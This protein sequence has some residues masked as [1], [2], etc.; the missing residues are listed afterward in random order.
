MKVLAIRGANLASLEGEFELD[1]AEGPLARAGVFAICGA[2][3]SGKSTLLDAMCLALFDSAPRLEGRV[4]VGRADEDESEWLTTSDPRSILRKGAGAGFAE[5]DFL[6][7]DGGRYRARWQAH[8][9][10][11]KA[12]GKLQ[13]ST[14]S[15][16]DLADGQALG[17]GRKTDVLTAI[18][19]HLG[20]TYVQFRRSVLLAQN[21]FAAF[22]D[23]DARERAGLLERMTGTEIYGLISMEAHVRAGEERRLLET[24]SERSTRIEVL[25]EAERGEHERRLT[26][27][28]QQVLANEARAR[29]AE[30]AVDWHAQLESLRGEERA[31]C[32]EHEQTV[33]QLA[34]AESRR[35]ELEAYEAVRSLRPLLEAVDR[36][37]VAVSQRA[38]ELAR[39]ETERDARIEQLAADERAAGAAQ[40]ALATAERARTDAAPLL[41]RA[42]RL[43]GELAVERQ[44]VRE[45]EARLDALR[46]EDA[47]LAARE[48][49]L[50]AELTA[51]GRQTED[52]SAWLRERERWAG[53]AEGWARHEPQLERVVERVEAART[54]R[55]QA[56]EAAEALGRAQAKHERAADAARLAAER[57]TAAEAAHATALAVVDDAPPAE[58][59][60]D[61][62][63]RW[64]ERRSALDTMLGMATSAQSAFEA[65][66][67]QREAADDAARRAADARHEAARAERARDEIELGLEE[68]QR[69]RDALRATLDLANRRAE[70]R[71]GEPCPLCGA[72]EHPFAH[73]LPLVES[74][75]NEQDARVGALGAERSRLERRAAEAL[76]AAK[77]S[78]DA[79]QRAGEEASR[80]AEQLAGER[81]RYREAA[82]RLGAD[83]ASWPRDLPS[84]QLPRVDGGP[85]LA[86]AGGEADGP[87]LD[88]GART[89]LEAALGD[90]IEALR[91]VDEQERARR[92]AERT[93]DA[94]RTTRDEARAEAD[95]AARAEETAR[96]TSEQAQRER[97]RLEQAA[98]EAHA[99]VRGAVEPLAHVLADELRARLVDDPERVL[100]EV[101][102]EVE[103]W[104]ARSTE[105][106]RAEERIRALQPTR[107]ALRE[108]RAGLADQRANAHGELEAA[109][110]ALS[111]ARAA[112]QALLGGEDAD[113]CEQRLDGALSQARAAAATA[114][115]AVATTRVEAADR[116]ARRQSAAQALAEA[117]T[118]AAEVQARLSV[119]CA[120]AGVTEP[121]ARARLTRDPVELD[122]W[123]RELATLDETR[124][125]QAAV[126]TERTRKREAHE[127]EDV[128]TLAAEQARQAVTEARERA[129]SS[130]ELLAS[131]RERLMRDDTQRAELRALE[132]E[133]AARREQLEVWETLAALIGSATGHKLRVFAQSLTLELLL[134]HANHHLRT[135]APRYALARVPGEDLA[136]MVIDR[137]MGD[138]VRGVGSLSG[139]ESFLVALGMAL[140]LASLSSH[141]AQI[142]S[143]FIDEGFGAL[144]P[145]SLDVVLHALDALQANGRQIGV[146]SHVQAMAERFDTRVQVVPRGPA[147]SRVE[148]VEGF[149]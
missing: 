77:G 55:A 60:A 81:A 52:A 72:R 136:L 106:A 32:E 13:P 92:E 25:P 4:R 84:V 7:I 125:R 90:A 135:L 6:G 48:G 87:L 3:G 95:R 127:R 46:G 66:R 45:R 102:R 17:G 118:A 67:R 43:E 50:E 145:A 132:E 9:A 113:A 71:E 100:D 93:A 112:R 121:D 110:G 26:E 76:E 61:V 128:P 115:R 73:E 34:L 119:A 74:L 2:T 16:L 131:I 147:R 22:L 58:R 146:I 117:H 37:E 28:D 12:R 29:D 124:R 40:A 88:A 30:R 1:L 15:L 98:A 91:R 64:M 139:G 54:L 36:A 68:A 47:R 103:A 41:A 142:G 105:R 44:H 144:D 57:A 51:C 38:T 59:L 138:E 33:R 148:L 137:E 111:T 23:A 35:L 8:R 24:L 122:L 83:E 126:L 11:G 21:D 19:A 129:A 39:T 97:A 107:D 42:R 75:L 78:E 143:L 114:A 116:A 85:L 149:G 63:A 104:L 14:M 96:D 134:E 62:R 56:R 18:E 99:K 108:Q 141:R 94:K 49:E 70:L 20:L 82:D 101:K 5:V 89:A 130:R 27:L 133:L 31:A 140:G 86:M 123:R 120:E 80:W 69:A 10:H 109:R 65:A 53:L 79:R